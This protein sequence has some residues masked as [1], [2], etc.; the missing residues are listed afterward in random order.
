ML[1]RPG[2]LG[3]RPELW[4]SAPKKVDFNTILYYIIIIVMNI[5]YDYNNPTFRVLLKI[6]C[7]SLTF[8]FQISLTLQYVYWA[9][10]TG[11]PV[12]GK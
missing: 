5:F 9:P 2:Y 6:Y 10:F 1:S 12:S 11:S 3:N 4:P 7:V 8:F